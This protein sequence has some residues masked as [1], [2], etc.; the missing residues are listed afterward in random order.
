MALLVALRAPD[1]GDVEIT[2]ARV[3]ATER[4]KPRPVLNSGTL[5]AAEASCCRRFPA[6]VDRKSWHRQQAHTQMRD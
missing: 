6:S 4:M 1:H 2:T 5:I 3:P